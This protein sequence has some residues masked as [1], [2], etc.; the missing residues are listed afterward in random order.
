[1]RVKNIAIAHV[2]NHLLRFTI[3]YRAVRSAQSAISELPM[4]FLNCT[5]KGVPKDDLFN[6]YNQ[7]PSDIFCICMC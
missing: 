7:Q 3:R 4:D 5:K 2:T 6:F 1:M